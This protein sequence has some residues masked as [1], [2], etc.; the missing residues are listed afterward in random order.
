MGLTILLWT[1]IPNT[2]IGSF[3]GDL[4]VLALDESSSFP[5][6]L[7]LMVIYHSCTPYQWNMDIQSSWLSVTTCLVPLEL[8]AL[9]V[10]SCRMVRVCSLHAL[11]FHNFLSV[12]T[13]SAPWLHM[14]DKKKALERLKL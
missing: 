7:V 5:W 13:L 12:G 10:S 6:S 11:V 4:G 8:Q 2:I 14:K 3:L 9:V 1:I